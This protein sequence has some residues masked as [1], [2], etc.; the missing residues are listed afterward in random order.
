MTAQS[1]HTSQPYGKEEDEKRRGG[2]RRVPTFCFRFQNCH[3][4][5]SILK[6]LERDDGGLVGCESPWEESKFVGGKEGGYGRTSPGRTCRCSLAVS[7]SIWMGGSRWVGVGIRW[8]SG[9]ER[10]DGT[11]EGCMCLR[12][13]FAGPWV[14][15]LCQSACCVHY[16]LAS[17]KRKYEQ[18]SLAGRQGL[19]G[20]QRWTFPGPSVRACIRCAWLF[21]VH[22]R[23]RAS[24][25]VMYIVCVCKC[26][27]AGPWEKEK[28][29]PR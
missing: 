18:G 16:L 1:G 3:G 14:W 24:A 20:K 28:R 15:L 23:L 29:T 6:H 11:L 19:W 10:W 22:L 17:R 12:P 5:S 21:C 2:R 7:C 25:S 27:S 26:M 4:V 8:A 13:L 9:M